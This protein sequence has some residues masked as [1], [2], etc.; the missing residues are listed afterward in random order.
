MRKTINNV[1][2]G[3]AGGVAIGM[4]I[5]P[6][7]LVAAAISPVLFGLAGAKVGLDLNKKEAR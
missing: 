5:V 2:L 4:V 6:V 7:Y 1:M 3:A